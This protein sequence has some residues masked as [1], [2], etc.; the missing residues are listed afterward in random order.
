MTTTLEQ[1]PKVAQAIIKVRDNRGVRKVCP[2]CSKGIT[3]GQYAT[4]VNGKLTHRDCAGTE[5]KLDAC[6]SCFMIASHCT[7]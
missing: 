5:G 7:C 4:N 2:E 1:E 6:T 3:K